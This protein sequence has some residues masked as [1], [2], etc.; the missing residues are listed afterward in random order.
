[1]GHAPVDLTAVGGTSEKRMVLCGIGENGFRD[2]FAYLVVVD[3]EGCDDVDVADL[4]P[5]DGGVHEAGDSL[6]VRDLTVFVDALDEGGGAVPTPM[7]ATLILPTQILL[8]WTVDP[9]MNFKC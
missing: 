1:M 5:T 4:I 6:V 7:I 3:V 8:P 2:V 9:G